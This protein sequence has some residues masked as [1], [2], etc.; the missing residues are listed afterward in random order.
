MD[1]G[2]IILAYKGTWASRELQ[3]SGSAILGADV[4]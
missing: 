1:E 3:S 2:Y 4:L